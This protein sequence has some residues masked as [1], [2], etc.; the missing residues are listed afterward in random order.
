MWKAAPEGE[1]ERLVAL[2]DG[3]FAIAVTLLVLDL[4]VPPGLDDEQYRD[5]LRDVLPNLGAYALSFFVL[6]QFWRD[7]RRIFRRVRH[8]DSQ[9]VRLSLLG[10]G[11]AA[12]LPFPTTLISE[13]P[14]EAVSV[15]VYSA[16]VTALG[17]THLALAVLLNRR[18]WLREAPAGDPDLLLS[19]ADLIATVAVFAVTIPLAQVLDGAAAWWWVALFPAKV[20]LGARARRRIARGRPKG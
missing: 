14:Q 11:L 16:A 19:A 15:V 13:Y 9:I 4:S 2:A 6:A 3:V 5:A 18:P 8:V 17:A 20:I 7:H 12:L 10:M 1:P